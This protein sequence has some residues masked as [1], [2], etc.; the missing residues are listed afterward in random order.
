[1]TGHLRKLLSRLWRKEDGNTGVE[2]MLVFPVY[3][4]LL[5][6]SLELSLITLRHTMLERGLDIAVRDIRLGTGTAPTHDEIKQRICDEALI[7]SNCGSNLRLEMMPTD[8]RA[9]G[10]L[11]DEA[12]CTDQAQE[13]NPVRQFTPGQQNDLMLMRACVK[14]DPLFPT[15]RIGRALDT[16]A[17]G[18]AALVSL[19]TFVQEPL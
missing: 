9:L 13:S 4:A 19:T 14:Y 1:M 16:D 12:D 17:S 5:G 6:M 8:I 11:N 2:F 10:A 3:L 18:Q 15:W 7:I